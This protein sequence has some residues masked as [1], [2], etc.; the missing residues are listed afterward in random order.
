MSTKP[1]ADPE[2]VPFEGLQ[3]KAIAEVD[4]QAVR[5]AVWL[6]MKRKDGGIVRVWISHPS[7][8]DVPLMVRVEVE[9]R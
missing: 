7:R 8:D 5:N 6:F 3:L 1:V 9:D 2:P 4:I